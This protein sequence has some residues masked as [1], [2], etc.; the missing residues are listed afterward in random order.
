MKKSNTL[1]VLHVNILKVFL[2]YKFSQRN[3]CVNLKTKMWFVIYN[4]H[5]GLM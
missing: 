3:S 4:F 1:W 5:V 2:A